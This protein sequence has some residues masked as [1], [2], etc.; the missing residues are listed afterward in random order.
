M[1][2]WASTSFEVLTSAADRERTVADLL[3]AQRPDG[4][5]SIASLTENPGDPDRQTEEGR[6]ARALEGH[7]R[8][9]LVFVGREKTYQSSLDSDG[10]ATGFA[11][12]VLRQ[13]GIPADDPRLQQGVAWLKQHQRASGRWFTPAQSWS[14]QHYISNAGNAYVIMALAACGELP[15]DQ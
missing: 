14:T 7:G 11:I 6:A 3:A 13:A 15:S 4:G 8:D 1:L 5:W 10:Y 9:F 12:F 2:V